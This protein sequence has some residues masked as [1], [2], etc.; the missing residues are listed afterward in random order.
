MA[1]GLVAVVVVLVLD[2]LV[3]VVVVELS[4]L[5]LQEK[6]LVP[7]VVNYTPVTGSAIVAFRGETCK[8]RKDHT[9]R[10]LRS[11]NQ[12]F[13]TGHTSPRGGYVKFLY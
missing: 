1:L 9:P 10:K 12:H 3:V 6:L 13:P 4:P 2:L 11:R 5:V 7:N 8:S